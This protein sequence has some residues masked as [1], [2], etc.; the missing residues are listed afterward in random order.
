MGPLLDMKVERLRDSFVEVWRFKP[1]PRLVFHSV[2]KRMWVLGRGFRFDGDGFHPTGGEPRGVD[3]LPVSIGHRDPRLRGQWREFVRTHYGLAPTELVAGELA[4]PESVVALGRL[5]SI[6][7]RTDRNDGGSTACEPWDHRDGVRG[8]APR[9]TQR[10]RDGV[11]TWQHEFVDE[12]E[13]LRTREHSRPIVLTNATGT[14]IWFH[15]G[16]YSVR[17]GWLVG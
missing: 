10:D 7:Y 2:S 5:V 12:G 1:M 13:P 14:G 9:S 17:N 4:P 8:C 16:S 11:S 3:R 6:A 15:G